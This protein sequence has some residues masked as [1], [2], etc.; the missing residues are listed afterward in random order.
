MQIATISIF[1]KNIKHY[2]DTVDKDQ[3]PLIITR[4]DN[5]AVVVLPLALYNTVSWLDEENQRK[6][7]VRTRLHRALKQ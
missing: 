4:S 3:E 5:V 6:Q 2:I 1:R 7:I